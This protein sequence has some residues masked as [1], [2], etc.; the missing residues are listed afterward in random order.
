[1][2]LKS[3]DQKRRNFM[4]Y[5]IYYDRAFIRVNDLY[6]PIVNQGSNNCWE[7]NFLSG[8]DVPEKNWQ[9]LNWR[10]RTR[11][12]YSETEVREIARG[13]EEISQNS[14]TCF[15]SRNRPFEA[16]ELERWILCGLKSA[17][18]IEEY[19]AAGNRLEIH[20][21]SAGSTRD[22]KL[23]PFSTT[24]QF[25]ALI[26][27]LKGRTLL[28]IHFVNNREIHRPIRYPDY[29]NG[30]EYYVLSRT[31]G[32]AVLFFRKLSRRGYYSTR[33]LQ[34]TDVRP[35]K[36]KQAAQRYLDKY[37]DRLG[38]GGFEVK[39]VQNMKLAS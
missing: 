11:L 20:D 16:G 28:N 17:F 31:N 39:K 21:Y 2:R 4:S 1:M 36:T 22:W 13:Y 32:S 8:R 14:G 25:L 10:D 6:I 33:N 18:T 35:F 15:K 30:Q 23:Y 9:V 34:D 38:K 7:H 5:E 27:K 37:K 26:D 12:L 3:S 29:C 24:G 19:V